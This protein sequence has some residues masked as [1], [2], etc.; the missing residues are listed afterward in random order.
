MAVLAEEG[1]VALAIVLGKGAIPIVTVGPVVDALPV[2]HAILGLAQVEVP[3][4]IGEADKAVRRCLSLLAAHEEC[5]IVLGIAGDDA[6]REA[7]IDVLRVGSYA[8][9]ISLD[10]YAEDA[11]TIAPLSYP[12]V[13]ALGL[14][15]APSEELAASRV[16]VLAS[17]VAGVVHHGAFGVDDVGKHL[18]HVVGGERV[19]VGVRLR[20]GSD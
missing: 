12:S 14:V 16:S 19:A 1:A 20:M 9:H 2:A 18:L 6:F 17:S 5:L 10:E 4:R 13:A 3:S 15:V 7:V 11:F 8:A